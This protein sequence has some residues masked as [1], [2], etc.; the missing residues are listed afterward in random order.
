MSRTSTTVGAWRRVL[1]WA[2]P[3]LALGLVAAHLVLT[4]SGAEKKAQK[5]SIAESSSQAPSPPVAAPAPPREKNVSVAQRSYRPP[6]YDP[7][8]KRDIQ[9]RSRRPLIERLKPSKVVP[10]V[11]KGTSFENLSNKNTS[12]KNLVDVFG[13]GG[14]AAGAYGHRVGSGRLVAHGGTGTANASSGAPRALIPLDPGTASRWGAAVG[15]ATE[16]AKAGMT[17]ED[18]VDAILGS[19]AR[20]PGE[21]PDMMFFRYY[22]DN[23]FVETGADPLSTFGVDVDTASYTLVRNYLS[24]GNLPPKEAVRTEEF[25]NYFRA[26]YPP[27][28]TGDFA[29]YTELAPSPFAHEK[30]YQLL[31]IGVKAREIPAEQRKPCALVFVLDVSGSMSRECRLELVK[32]SLRILVSRLDERDSIGIVTFNTSAR[33]LLDPVGVDHAEDILKTIDVLHPGGSTNAGDGLLLGYEMAAAHLLKGGN[34]RVVLCSDGVANTGVTNPEQILARVKEYRTKGIFLNSIGVGMGNHND[35]L[36]ERLADAG[37]GHCVYVDRLAEARTVFTKKL[38]GTME[39]IAKDTKIQVAFDPEKVVLYRLLGYENRAVADKDFRNDTVDAGEIGAGHEVTACY[40][41]LPLAGATGDIARVSLRYKPV[42][43]NEVENA[44]ETS[45]V[46]ST[47]KAYPDFKAASCRLRLNAVVAEF[48]EILRR[49]H[50]ARGS[51]LE[52]LLLH[53]EPLAAAFPGERDVAEFIALVK[54]TRRLLIKQQPEDELTQAVGAIKENYLLRARL[55]TLEQ[56]EGM[57]E[58]DELKQQ[59]EELKERIR[60]ILLRRARR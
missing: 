17:P 38:M 34:N 5:V 35:A 2:L 4:G 13:L 39:T 60:Q 40:E 37:D 45:A 46:V 7:T 33:K 30:G 24:R 47:A 8:L 42:A 12:H 15:P 3:M 36:L 55:A 9:S 49:S 10:N 56:E 44:V 48:A 27:P 18:R 16:P 23:P 53:A 43:G 41:I 21:T 59:N 11:P 32:Q 25:I 29:I 57:R 58:L 14:G 20:R 19:L 28:R 22:G 1:P 54:Q 52:N 6:P 31:R 50:W 26:G 51:T